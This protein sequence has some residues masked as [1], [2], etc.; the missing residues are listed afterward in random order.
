MPVERR[1][2]WSAQAFEAALFVERWHR[3]DGPS[4]GWSGLED[5]ELGLDDEVAGALVHVL[6]ELPRAERAA[7]APLA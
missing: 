5:F 4:V 2:R 6:T 3:R 1:R 7:F